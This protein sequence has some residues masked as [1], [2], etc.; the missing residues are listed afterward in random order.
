MK[1]TD[2][3]GL[4]VM[5]REGVKK[6][7]NVKE[8]AYDPNDHMVKALIVDE[9]G[10]F[11]DA[12]VILFNDIS[13]IGK[14]AVMIE[15]ERL[16]R[17]ASEITQSIKRIVKGDT[18]LTGNKIITQEGTELGNVSDIYFDAAS[19]KVYELEVSQ[20]LKNI[21]SGKKRIKVDDIV[22]IGEDATMVRS[23]VEDTLQQQQGGVQGA[24]NKTV[25]VAQDKGPGVIEQTKKTADSLSK[26]AKKTFEEGK[27]KIT[28]ERKKSVVGKYLTVNI[29][30]RNDEIIARRSDIVTHELLERAEE[31]GM[32]GNVLNN[33]SSE[34]V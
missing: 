5:A 19:G 8:I 2:V 25:D 31:N 17:K 11:S 16:I 18:F 10:W 32:L 6:I 27:E 24:V 9:G 34:P 28:E 14:D 15:S 26:E 12:K 33:I 4:K 29:L 30:G 20:G 23:Y 13:S 21:Q 3:I 22:K 1:G 7:D